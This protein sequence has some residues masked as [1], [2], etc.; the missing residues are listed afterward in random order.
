MAHIHAIKARRTHAS[1]QKSHQHATRHSLHVTFSIRKHQIPL[2]R[3]FSASIVGFGYS[4]NAHGWLCSATCREKGDK[5]TR[6]CRKPY[7]TLARTPCLHNREHQYSS[8]A[9]A[10]KN[11]HRIVFLSIF[12]IKH[13]DL[14]LSEK[15]D[16]I[17]QIMMHADRSIRHQN[18][19]EHSHMHD[20]SGGWDR[21]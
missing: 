1:L 12:S 15:G 2:S 9:I 6:L 7:Q 5:R 20:I 13:A 10:N 4:D 17:M 11:S 21:K 18:R 19:T 3:S 16:P 8:R 14:C